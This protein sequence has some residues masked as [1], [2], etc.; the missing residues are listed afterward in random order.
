M[1]YTTILENALIN[2]LDE[3]SILYKQL[4]KEFDYY[5][6]LRRLSTFS[7]YEAL[8]FLEKFGDNEEVE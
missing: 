4:N 3:L 5:D 1:D 6:K 8:A 2:A 7:N